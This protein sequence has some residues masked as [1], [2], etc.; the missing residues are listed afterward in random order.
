GHVAPASWLLAAGALLAAVGAGMLAARSRPRLAV[1]GALFGDLD[2]VG[3]L[4]CVALL[5]LVGGTT[6]TGTALVLALVAVCAVMATAKLG[7]ARA[8]AAGR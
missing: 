5:V 8:A 6:T 3:G 1:A 2:V 7:L 4:G